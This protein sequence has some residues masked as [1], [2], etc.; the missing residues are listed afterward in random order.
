MSETLTYHVFPNDS[1]GGWTV[2]RETHA[3]PLADFASLED[4][5]TFARRE[6]QRFG[7]ADLVVHDAAGN[8]E[9]TEQ[10]IMPRHG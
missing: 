10:A 7:M 1:T 8:I 4:A 3:E 2:S 9:R 6:C 5:L